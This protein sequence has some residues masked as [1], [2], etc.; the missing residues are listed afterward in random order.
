MNTK[1]AQTEAE[2][3]VLLAV[4]PQDPSG[5]RTYVVDLMARQ[6]AHRHKGAAI[7]GNILGEPG[8]HM[9]ISG[10]AS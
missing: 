10:G 3:F 5:G 8:L 1:R 7:L 9:A 4:D 6:T 2:L